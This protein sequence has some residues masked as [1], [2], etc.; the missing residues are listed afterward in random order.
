VT[1]PSRIRPW[2]IPIDLVDIDPVAATAV[3]LVGRI[4][5]D[6]L[7]VCTATCPGR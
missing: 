1:G 4:H 7:R 6:L 5:V 3:L 2:H